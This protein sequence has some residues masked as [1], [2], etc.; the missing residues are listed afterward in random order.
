MRVATVGSIIVAATV[1]T[2]PA[3][4]VDQTPLLTARADGRSVYVSFDLRADET[5]DLDRRLDHAEPV[6]VTWSIDLRRKIPLWIDRDTTRTE[7]KVSARRGPS[8]EM[9][10]VER[11]VNGRSLGPPLQVDRAGALRHLLSFEALE[12]VGA[13]P[14][15]ST[16]R[17]RL[18][19]SG[20]LAGGGQRRIATAVLADA[21][22]QP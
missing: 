18:S 20:E 6:W 11:V 12:L 13:A 17:L 7:L 21:V 4:A 14:T 3:G 16:E 19:V 2:A 10:S 9:Y 15:T 22:V 8:A 5:P 1:A